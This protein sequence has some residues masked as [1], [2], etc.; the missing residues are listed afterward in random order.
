METTHTPTQEQ[1]QKHTQT[2]VNFFIFRSLSVIRPKRGYGAILKACTAVD[3]VTTCLATL[4]QVDEKKDAGA[5][6]RK[7]RNPE[8]NLF[9]L[10][11]AKVATFRLIPDIATQT[12]VEFFSTSI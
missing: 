1:T 8:Q 9:C 10:K 7:K 4:K 3:R 2:H 6:Q 5:L 11:C 12:V